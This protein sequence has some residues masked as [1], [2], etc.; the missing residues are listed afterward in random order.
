MRVLIIED[1]RPAADRLEMLLKRFDPDVEIIQ[2]LESVSASVAWFT[3]NAQAADLV[4]MDIRLTD[5]L[6]FEIFKQVPINKPVIFTT[7]YNE[8]ALEAFKVNSIDYLLK[9]VSYDDLYRSMNKLSSLREN[10]LS[11]HQRVELEELAKLL[12]QFQRSYKQRFM[13][14]VGDHIRS[15][16]VDQ[17]TLFYADG[18]VVYVFTSLGREYIVDFKMEELEEILDPE[19]FFRINRTFTINING[20]RDVIIHSNSRL[21]ILLQQAFD[22]EL[23]VS[24]EK[25]NPF[26]MWFGMR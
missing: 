2:R 25:I 11:G 18:R 6:S 26:K 5:G 14:K 7:A 19:L 12:D 24:R 13:V 1:E 20:I 10:L 3:R 4:F 21:K 15:I 9:P 8:Y 22:Q 17:I 16:P 23:I